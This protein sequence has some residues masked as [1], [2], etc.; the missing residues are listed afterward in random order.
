MSGK[1]NRRWMRA[2]GVLARVLPL[3]LAASLVWQAPR[4]E[5]WGR[6]LAAK[7]EWQVVLTDHAGRV[8]A[9]AAR[10]ELRSMQQLT[11]GQRGLAL[12]IV[13]RQPVL[14]T[15]LP[16]NGAGTGGMDMLPEAEV[17]APRVG[18]GDRWRDGICMCR[19]G[20]GM[21]QRHYG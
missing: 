6:A 4:Q 14:A 13:E 21:R 11:T 10:R 8:V 20:I 16:E 7:G 1:S 9:A 12:M 5:W 18:T 17:Q 2:R 19:R 3:V 15:A